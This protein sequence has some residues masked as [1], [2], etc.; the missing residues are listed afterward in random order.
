MMCTAGSL[1]MM[2][3]ALPHVKKSKC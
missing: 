1:R 3:D 2:D